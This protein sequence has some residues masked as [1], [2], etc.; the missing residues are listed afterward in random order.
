MADENGFDD[1][2]VPVEQIR[3]CCAPGTLDFETTKDLEPLE[4]LIGQDRAMDAIGLAAGMR[5]HD[6]NLFVLGPSGTGRHDA[7]RGFLQ[8]HSRGRSA[9]NDWAYVNNFDAP[10]RPVALRLPPGRA[11]ALR[12]EMEDL[13]DD[14]AI[15]I[16]A[17]FESDE[18]QTTRRTL[19]QEYG[20]RQ[21]SAMADFA[22]K[23][24][25]EGIA[26]MRT[27]MGFMLTA[28]RD[29][30]VL[31]A[32]EFNKLPEDEQKAIQDKIDS[33]Q[34]ELTEVLQAAPKIERERR[35]KVDELNSEMTGQVVSAR[36]DEVLHAFDDLPDVQEYLRAVRK[37]MTANAEL[38]LTSEQQ[39]EDGA[40]FV[41]D[42]VGKAHR[43]PRLFRYSVN[44]MVSHG[45]ESKAGAPLETE[46]LPTLD[47]V[48]GR[49]EHVS[50]MGA[51][52]T[53]FT[54][55][56]PGALHRA[57]GGYL[58]LDA[59]RILSE[60]MAWPALKQC[61]QSRS[62]TITSMAERVGMMS[63]TSLEPDPI[64]LDLRVVLIGDRLLYS[65]LVNYDP[66]FLELFKLEADFE[67]TIDRSPESQALYA[68]LI[69]T[70]ARRDGLRP[71]AADGVARLIDESLRLAD[72]S[73]KLSLHLGKMGDL[74]READHYAGEDGRDTVGADDVAHAVSQRERRASRVKDR[75]REAVARRTLLIETEGGAVGQVN[76]LSVVGFG[77]FRFGQPSRITARTRMGAGKL[78]DIEREVELGGPLHSKGV[79][80]LGGY[81]SATYALDVPFSL[82][83]SLVFEQTY[84]GV[85][86]DSA[87]AAE[88]FALLSALSELP[89]GQN[90]AVTGSVDQTGKVQAIGGVNEKIEGFFET[91]QERGLT[92][93]QG[94]II[95]RSNVEHLML[96]AEVA[97]A[98]E[99][100]NFRI[101]AIETIDEGIAILTGRKAGRRGADGAYEAES[102]NALVEAQLVEFAHQR[103]NFAQTLKAQEKGEA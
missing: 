3:H 1:L 35:R 61:L 19:E 45:A 16:P 27:P 102:V 90:F 64:P 15:D 55:I 88:L 40:P 13:V 50:H 30:K 53:N 87:S 22:D 62:I 79:L 72:D 23:A 70:R 9:P 86:G 94:V 66:D 71:I 12:R 34:E 78:I 63:T 5:H 6:F 39:G 98:V 44:V 95:P 18:Y 92:G 77:G 89:V 17:L 84:G 67:E 82:H 74:L 58:V 36:V 52:M 32:E 26:L 56:K 51:L 59:R 80:I 85:D 43:D 93:D 31:K 33:L 76:G 83:A 47:R 48:T 11:Q 103:Q 91:C 101:F 99:A 57:N 38:F 96:R 25:A 73:T 2:I 14:L 75:M 8:D 41:H 28:I 100:G 68:R 21:E 20:S 81:L 65:L 7:V 46:T 69:G 37:D 49:I 54:M 60:P 42:N 24:K 10:H 29:G 97:E 4:G